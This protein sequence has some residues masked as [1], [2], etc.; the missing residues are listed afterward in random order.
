MTFTR[1]TSGIKNYPNFYNADVVVY[2]EGSSVTNSAHSN[3]VPDKVFYEGLLSEIFKNKIIE[4]KCV[5]D[6]RTALSYVQPIIDSG[7]KNS[8]V[9]VDRDYDNLTCS[10]LEIDSLV[11]T[12]GY[13]WENDLWSLEVTRS[14]LNDLTFQNADAE[15]Q[16]EIQYAEAL[17]RLKILSSFDA[18]AQTASKCILPKNGGAC[19]INIDYKKNYLISYSELKRLIKKFHTICDKNCLIIKSVLK[20]ASELTANK[21][22]QGHLFEHVI[23]KLI[24]NIYTIKTGN[25]KLPTD[26]IKTLV[27]SKFRSNP[28][29][30]LEIN[31][32]NYYNTLLT[33]KIQ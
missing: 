31:T 12:Y 11:Y 28:K 27:L 2:I 23:N 1:T 10:I 25:I 4:V 13:S 8:V 22:I 29:Q 17:K 18:A 15:N 21:L 5:G 6:K 32:F 33:N 24:S 26:L 30:Y 19:G 20:N 3:L 9:I 14:V 7:L 16:L